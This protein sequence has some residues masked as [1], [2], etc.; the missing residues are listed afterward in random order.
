M[1]RYATILA[2]SFSLTSP[3]LAQSRASITLQVGDAAT[4]RLAPDGAATVAEQRGRAEWTDYDV[5]VARHLSGLPIPERAVPFASPLGRDVAPQEPPVAPDI[6]RVKFLSIAGQHSLLVIE[7]GYDRAI[8]Y[9]ARMVRGDQSRPTDVCIV[10][11]RKHGF[12]HWPF[13][14]ERLEISD[15]HFV[16]WRAG[17]PIPCA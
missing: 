5:A 12:E 14:I 8:A 1:L 3:A 11:P 6:V 4:F 7:N 15:M 13:V 2:V 10:I 17:D 16:D 9:R